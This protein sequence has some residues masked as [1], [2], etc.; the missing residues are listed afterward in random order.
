MTEIISVILCTSAIF[1]AIMLNLAVRPAVSR[2]LIGFAV[3]ITAVGGLLVY[4]Y[5][6]A[7]TVHSIPLAVIRA[8]FAVCSI[9]VGGN[10]LNDIISA[11]LLQYTQAQIVFWLL[12]LMGLFG[13]TSAVITAIGSRVLR[14]L[15]MWLIRNQD[16]AIIYRLTPNTLEFGRKLLEQQ[17]LSLV[18]VDPDGEN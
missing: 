8:T 2:K 11:P 7:C 5:G 18:Y 17:K 1:A 3:G 12:H 14:Q 15:R 10:S 13:S 6:Y 9:F 4:G 16:L